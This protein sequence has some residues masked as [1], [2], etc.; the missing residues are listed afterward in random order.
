MFVQAKIVRMEP[1]SGKSRENF[2][3]NLRNALEKSRDSSSLTDS[4]IENIMNEANSFTTTEKVFDES[5][6][7][8]IH[9]T[10]LQTKYTYYCVLAGFVIY[11]A[12]G[13]FMVYV[14]GSTIRELF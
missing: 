6:D 10:Y 8:K 11:F 3:L 1:R 13:L 7:Q 4:E 14:I 2:L 12:P 5:V 9:Y